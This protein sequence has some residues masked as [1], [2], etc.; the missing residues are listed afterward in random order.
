MLNDYHELNEAFAETFPVREESNPDMTECPKHGEVEVTG[1][2]RTGGSDPYAIEY[3]ACGCN[4]V[5]YGPGE[6]MTII[7]GRK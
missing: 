1:Y 7:G 6:P 2:G 5:C 4:L 3:A